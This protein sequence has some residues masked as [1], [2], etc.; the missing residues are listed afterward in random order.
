MSNRANSGSKWSDREAEKAGSTWAGK[1]E[2]RGDLR[3]PAGW[4]GGTSRAGRWRGRAV[5]LF[6]HW[7][8]VGGGKWGTGRKQRHWPEEHSK[9]KFKSKPGNLQRRGRSSRGS[10]ESPR[11]SPGRLPWGTEDPRLSGTAALPPPQPR[12]SPVQVPYPASRASATLTAWSVRHAAAPGHSCLWKRLWWS[13][14]RWAPPSHS[15]RRRTASS[16]ATA[17]CSLRPCPP[18]PVPHAHQGPRSGLRS[19]PCDPRRLRRARSRA[20]VAAAPPPFRSYDAGERTRTRLSGHTHRAAWPRW[21]VETKSGAGLLLNHQSATSRGGSEFCHRK[22]TFSSSFPL[23]LFLGSR[24]VLSRF[25]YQVVLDC[26]FVI[27]YSSIICT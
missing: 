14:Q 20:R 11:D 12:P 25:F 24:T 19:A 9:L 17:P 21:K 15:A 5:V 18:N 1:A 2:A 10:R 7:P 4:G 22:A 27:A 6:P 26:S 13:S 16:P 3:G 23:L 8:G